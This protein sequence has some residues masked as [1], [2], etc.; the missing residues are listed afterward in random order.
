MG[1]VIRSAGLDQ[2]SLNAARLRE[3][4]IRPGGLWQ[5]IRVV[6]ETGSTNA[7]LLA[8]AASGAPEG[9]VLVAEAQS[10]GRGRMGRN[11]VS[12]PRAA[13]TFSVLLRPA[14]VPAASR[15]WVPLLAGVAMASSLRAG[16]GVDARLKW[17]NDL[18]AGG[19]KLGGILAEQAGEA[20]VVGA[21]IN[22]SASSD[23]LPVPAAASLAPTSLALLGAA[24]LDRHRLL[25][26][27]LAEFEHWYRAWAGQLGDAV[28]SGL[29]EEYRGL[30][31]TLGRQ[32]RISMPGGREVTGLA[33]DVDASG[34]L[35]VDSA[36]GLVA[37]S[38]GDVVHV[39]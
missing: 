32:V 14:A 15:S 29:R 6:A 38:A 26:G 33:S 19:G 20:I 24:C 34:R 12:P 37:V 2:E 18:M 13:L 7:D 25:A 23:E 27:L 36:S 5:D 11:W 3:A 9:V 4:V 28:A 30:C 17:P 8:E 39:R 10:A 21:G 31:A 16:G 35:V 22:V 1:H